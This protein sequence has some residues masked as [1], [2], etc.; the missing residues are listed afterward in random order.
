MTV[1][2]NGL[3]KWNGVLAYCELAG[4]DP[5]R[6][7]AIGDGAN[8]REILTNASVALVPEDAHRT[9]SAPRTT[10]C[11]R[12]PSAAGPPSS[13]TC[14]RLLGRARTQ[15]GF[16]G[17]VYSAQRQNRAHESPAVAYRAATVDDRDAIAALWLAATA[18][19]AG[20]TSRSIPSSSLR[21]ETDGAFAFVADDAGQVVGS[22][23][24]SPGLSDRGAGP[25][26]PG[27]AHLNTVAVAPGRWG[28]G[29]AR[30]LLDLIV[31]AAHE[32]GYARIQLFTQ[33]HNDRARDLYE[34][35]DWKLTGDE[36]VDTL[37]DTLVRYLRRV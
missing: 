32:H 12:P 34:R 2:P 14:D 8:D 28:E 15:F 10:W 20:T 18:P 13:T 37:G 16:H 22:A 11:R 9:R 6:V 19:A 24:L 21:I 17:R 3:S 25:A 4:I 33:D 30:A 7:L 35:N 23:I 1:G 31:D 26:I 29:I 36:I 5:N 27:L